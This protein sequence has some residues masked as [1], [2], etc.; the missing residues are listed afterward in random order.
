MP[1]DNSI[2]ERPGDIWWDERQPL[3]TLRTAMN[4]VRMSYL[5]AV[6]AGRGI[7]PAGTVIVDVGCGGGMLAEELAAL[8]ARWRWR[9]PRDRPRSSARG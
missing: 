1:A 6:L 5:R 3:H 4:P 7:D 2:Y 8:G 9:P